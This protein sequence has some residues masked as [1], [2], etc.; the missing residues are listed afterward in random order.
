M[1]AIFFDV[2][3]TL[4]HFTRDYRE[5]LAETFETVHGE[6][7]DRW[8]DAYNETFFDLLEAC[9]ANPYRRA[10]AATGLESPPE[11][12]VET[13]RQVETEM[14]QPP[15]DAHKHLE[16][17]AENYKLGVL[18]NGVPEWQKHKLESHGLRRYFDAIVISYDVGVHK[19]DI[20]PFNAAEAHLPA[21]EY[22]MVG[23]SDADID[24]AQKAGWSTFR[25][26]GGGFGSL[27]D[28][29]DWE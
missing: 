12:L 18:T 22:A 8:L 15:G 27:P 19:P 16:R 26:D 5:V 4:L 7:R 6:S 3:G 24:G 29:I 10:F 28:A 13:L 2:D 1:N 17:L 20:A 14:C 11:Q 25:Y 9:E 21:D 23:D